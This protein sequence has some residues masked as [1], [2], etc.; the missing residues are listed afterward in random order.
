MTIPKWLEWGQ[1]LQALARAGLTY[2]E[3]KFDVERYHAITA[4]AADMIATHAAADQSVIN[5]IYDSQAGYQTPKVD[6]RGVVF[7]DDKIL[8]VKE[9]ADGGWTLPGGWMDVN[10]TP[11]ENVARE[12]HEEAGYVVRPVKLMAVY[13]RRLHGHP[14]YIFHAYKLFFMCD[15][16]GGEATTSI[17]TGGAEFYALDELPPLSIERTTLE[18]LQRCFVHHHQP[19]LPTEFDY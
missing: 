10:E 9:L 13:D 19:D 15:L 12:V 1:K 4:I 2:T 6:A 14:P 17:E 18:E 7:K 5:S 8:L 11:G 3:N 16:L